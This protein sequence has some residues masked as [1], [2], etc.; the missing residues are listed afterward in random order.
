MILKI[1][2]KDIKISPRILQSDTSKSTGKKLEKISFDITLKGEKSH[3]SFLNL[4]NKSNEGGIFSIDENGKLSKEYKVSDKSYSYT[5]NITTEDTLFHYAVELTEIENLKIESLIISDIE[6]Y[7]YEYTERF[8]KN[9]LVINAKVKLPP[10]QI[11]ELLEK[12]KNEIYF[13][14]VRKGINDE[15]KTMRFGQLFW[16]KHE[17]VVK[18]H[19]ILV[20]KSYEESKNEF[21]QKMINTQNSLTYTSNSLDGLVELL[22]AKKLLS[23]KEIE[24]LANKAKDHIFEKTREFYEVDDIDLYPL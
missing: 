10:T 17:D 21:H 15:I 11:S 22:V 6:L 1:G 12:A 3:S 7:P 20:D 8:D 18:Y 13:P 14:V 16:S 9:A 23:V 5:G 2:D 19:L 24:S 4:L